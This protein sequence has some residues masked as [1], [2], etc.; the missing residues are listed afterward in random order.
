MFC[1]ITSWNIYSPLRDRAGFLD[2]LVYKESACNAG[3]TGDVCSI[4][5]S[6]RSSGE[7]NG[8]P[9]QHS[10]LKI[11]WAEE[12]GR[13]QSMGSQRVIQ[14]WAT[15]QHLNLRR[16]CILVVQLPLLYNYYNAIKLLGAEHP[17]YTN[18]AEKESRLKEVGCL[19]P[20]LDVH[21]QE[22]FENLRGAST[23]KTALAL[24]STWIALL[25]EVFKA[26]S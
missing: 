20:L 21:F 16:Q 15:Q 6:G 7:G 1:K 22:F 2:G 9:F 10:R 12:S 11:P 23:T 19:L 24:L 18:F 25:L 4:P 3:D 26:I 5:G 14:D 8:S 17:L 13:L